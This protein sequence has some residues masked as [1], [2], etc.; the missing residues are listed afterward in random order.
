MGGASSSAS[1]WALAGELP[2]HLRKTTMATAV[3]A[4]TESTDHIVL[5]HR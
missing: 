5:K 3:K 2:G 1:A 4:S